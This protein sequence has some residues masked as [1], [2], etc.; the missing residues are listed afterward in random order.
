MST[1]N[2][3]EIE[4]LVKSYHLGDITVAA[5]RGVSLTIEHGD[6]VAI[7]G[8]SGSGKSTLMNILGCLDKPT[9]GAYRL[10]GV[11]VGA[12]D[13]DQLAEIRNK[14]IGFV[15]QQFNLLART[16]ALENVELPLLY[17]DTPDRERRE[18]V[19][20][21]LA[22]VGLAQRADH[23]PSQLSG[24]Q[25]QRVAIARALVNRPQMLLADEPTGALDSRT[26]IEIMAIFRQLNREQGISTIVVTH[27]SDIAAYA[28]R[29]IHF[30]DGRLVSDEHVDRP[31]QTQGELLEVPEEQ[32]MEVV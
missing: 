23:H 28:N 20:Q 21:A 1:S 4:D 18:R 2:I 13:R 24:G 15:F 10:D 25:Q 14:K 9:T 8:P 3:I 31:R 7:M 5:L 29:V 17:T 19:M 26:S 27:E 12:L 16:S 22:A 32:P 6:F 11:G 30:R